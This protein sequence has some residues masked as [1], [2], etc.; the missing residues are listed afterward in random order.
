MNR[1]SA[2]A[3][4]PGIGRA[5]SEDGAPDAR[6]DGRLL[7]AAV[8]CWVATVLVL[9]A[10]WRV[11]VMIAGGATVAAIGLWMA[12]M[13][14][15]AHRRERW[16]AVAVVALGAIVLGTGFAVAAAWR[17]HRVQTH[18][19]RAV[20][21]G[22]SVRVVV[23]PVDDP[24]PVRGAAFGGERTWL[25]RAGLREYQHGSTIVRSGGA[26]VILATGSAWATLPPGQPV[27]FRARVAPPRLR[28]LTV[29]T[30][31]P[32][33]APAPAGPLPWWQR[34]AGS[35]RADLVTASAA[36]LPDAA[37]GSLPA[38]VVG[39]TS[40]LSDD[41][42]R[43]F[44]T[45]GLTHLTVVSGANF[46]ILLTV[47]L[48]LTRLLTLGPRMT[49]GVA[50]GA[51]VMFVVIARPD[52]S[53]LRAAAMGAVTLLALLTG[54]RRQALP[55]LCAAVIGLLALWPE[56]AMSAGFALS[57]LATGA[58]ILLAPSW[59]DWLRAKG[60]WRLPAEILAVSAAA[61]VVTTPI[62]VALTGKISLVAVVANVL[63]A[64]VIAPI[65]VVGAAGAVSATVW[66]PLAELVLRCATPPMWWLLSVAEYF[67]A[68]PGAMVAVPGG[69]SGGLIV[70]AVVAAG[71]WLLRSA[72]V[73]R[74]AAAVLI[75]AAAVLIPVRLWFSGWPPDGWAL[76]AC[77]VGQGDGL[78]LAA[79]AGSAVVIDVGPDSRAMRACL[80]R[81]DITRIPLLILSHPHADHIAGLD[82]ALHGRDVGAVAVGPGELPTHRSDPASGRASRV[83]GDQ[84]RPAPTRCGPTPGT[85]AH[86]GAADAQP[87]GAI[88]DMSAPSPGPGI[89]VAFGRPAGFRSLTGGD[90]LGRSGFD[91][92]DADRGARDDGVDDRDDGALAEGHG[93]HRDRSRAGP[94]EVAQT[95]H[96]TGIPVVELVAGCRLTVGDLVLDVLAPA[97]P[98]SP[99]GA[100]LD[101]DTANDR[102]IVLAAHTAVGSILFTGDIEAATQRSLLASRAPIHA[103]ILKVPHHGSRTTTPEFLRAVHP[104]LAIISA[105]A[106]NTFGHP[107]PGIL[108][109]LESMGTVIAR[110]DRDGSITL[111]AVDGNLEI[112]TTGATPTH[113]SR[114]PPQRR[115]G[116]RRGLDPGGGSSPRRA[117]VPTA[118]RTLSGLDRRIGGVSER[119]AAVHLVLGDEELLIERAIASVVA[120]VRAGAPDP[121]GVPVDRLRAGEASTAE[122]AELLSPSLFAE[123]R[124]IILESAAEAGKDAV[125][126]IAEA[127]AEPPD[128]VVLMVV[129][130]GGGRAKALAPA[131]QKAGAV[132]H[133]CAKLTKASERAEFVRAEFRAAGARVS[134][135]VVQAVIEAVGSDLRELA[136]ASSQLAA[137]TGGKIDVAA[138]RR[139]YSGKAEVTGFD[140]AELAV[141]GDRPGAMEALRWAN[142]RGVPHVLLA[143]ALAD[144]VHTIAKVGSAG[145]GD[146]FKLAGPL[147]MPPWKVKKAQA[148]SRGWTPATIGSALQ[149]VATLNADVKG[150][151]ADS[152]FA[153]EHALMQILDLH[154]R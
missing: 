136:A 63:V 4:E 51:L 115:R 138:V 41:V 137:D 23:T 113:R 22:M 49:A 148:Q 3:T 72:L 143:D 108:S 52:P 65:T 145:R 46:T 57:V 154:G 150:G 149:V 64:P 134:G 14:A 58:L 140:V 5:E 44:E 12:L 86:F 21:A 116:V 37:A 125:A 77:D 135:E 11:G 54:R 90:D 93:S 130:S 20:P 74:L 121:E 97:A 17:E 56:L 60:M 133:N 127:A 50:A 98:R 71:I 9:G 110:T 42:R 6:L 34:L 96:D 117:G 112:R 33:G 62:V 129:H 25:V 89:G 36:A 120:Q 122:L 128:G 111:R 141:T 35:V 94:A 124:V 70:C 91:G 144:S 82:G 78:A 19:L 29:A 100:P 85:T 81:L 126:V 146:P 152:A 101:L 87:S 26:V 32:L 103:D 43:D 69:S 139:Y 132:V 83:P 68:M 151:A 30:L 38:L 7:P 18:P 1:E 66:M 109:D 55:A 2:A 79:G 102:S 75:A 88:G 119:P 10:G 27:E 107:H 99:R 104:R 45:A 84:H 105:G 28:D 8:C 118:G 92:A 48:F 59:T 53:V 95:L 31:R 123:D 40:A 47:A 76:A 15:V 16:R 67:A 61:F 73:R 13:W 39:D 153:L 80:D 114:R 147:G 142:D 24:K 131:L 106:T